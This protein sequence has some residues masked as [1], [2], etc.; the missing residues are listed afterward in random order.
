MNHVAD[1]D[2]GPRT[3][4][5]RVLGAVGAAFALLLAVAAPVAAQSPMLAVCAPH[6]EVAERLDSKYSE[7]PAAIGLASNGGIIELFST[8]DGA[9]WTLVMT[10]P[11]GTSCTVAV[12]RAWATFPATALD[13]QA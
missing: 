1:E 5:I 7:A 8:A 3:A 9:T 2:Q 11:D 10:M 4:L 6:A 12:G 13:P